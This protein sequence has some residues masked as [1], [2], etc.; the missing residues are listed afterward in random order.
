MRA[1]A[2]LGRHDLLTACTMLAAQQML[3]QYGATIDIV[4]T[5]I[6]VGDGNAL[7]LVPT[8]RGAASYPDHCAL[9][10]PA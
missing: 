3:T 9:Q 4:F 5:D 7:T 10:S 1:V 8:L 6:N 2:K